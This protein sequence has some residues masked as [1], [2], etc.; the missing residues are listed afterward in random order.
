MSDEAAGAEAQLLSECLQA[1]FEVVDTLL[2]RTLPKNADLVYSLLHR[3][4]VIEGLAASH[5]WPDP[6]KVLHNVR[7]VVAHFSAAIDGAARGSG[8]YSSPDLPTSAVD[9]AASGSLPP[10][11]VSDDWSVDRVRQIIASKL[12][13]WR[14]GVLRPV[15]ELKFS[16]EEAQGAQEF[17][18]PYLWTLIVQ[19][20]CVALPKPSGE[21]TCQ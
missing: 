8:N 20:P 15:P 5:I 7:I 10:A 2:Y 1:L 19:H 3:Q 11:G 17:F 14:P 18:L 6:D 21:A 16:Y 13:T 4:Q 12:R 9:S